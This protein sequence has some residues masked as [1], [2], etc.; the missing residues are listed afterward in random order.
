MASIPPG[1]DPD[2]QPDPGEDPAAPWGRRVDGSPKGRGWLGMMRRADGTVASEMSIGVG[3]NG[4]EIDVPLMVPTLDKSEVKW[5]L[6]EPIDQVTK[7]VPNSILL[8]AI[9]HAKKR[10]RGGNSPFYE[11]LK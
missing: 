4:K 10:L 1:P 7:T 11:G 8:K 3:I 6:N 5:L 2:I 9:D